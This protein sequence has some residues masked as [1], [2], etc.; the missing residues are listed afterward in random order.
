MIA[1]WLKGD[2]S[3]CFLFTA[4]MLITDVI[5][6]SCDSGL[7]AKFKSHVILTSIFNS[8]GFQLQNVKTFTMYIKVIN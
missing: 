2:M 1:R 4:L 8:G 3:L 5:I 7:L 6:V